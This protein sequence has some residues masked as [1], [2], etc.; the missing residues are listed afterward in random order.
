MSDISTPIA[1]SAPGQR[2]WIASSLQRRFILLISVILSILSFS[3][4]TYVI[5]QYREKILE[6]HSRASLQV[7]RLLEAS[8]QNAMLKRDL[9]GLRDIVKRLGEQ[10]DISA[11]LILNP[12]LKVTF[13]SLPGHVGATMDTPTVR[14]ALDTIQ[15]QTEYLA[16]DNGTDVLRS[17]NPVKNQ[18][19]CNQCHGASASHPVNGMLVVDYKAGAVHQEALRGSL[20]LAG[21]G[22]IVTLLT[23]LGLWAGLKRLVIDRIE[24]LKTA[25]EKI[26][27]SDFSVRV[28]PTGS[29]EIAKLGSSFNTMAGQISATH[30]RLNKAERFLQDIIDAVP[31]GIRVIADDFRIIKANRQYAL[32]TGSQSDAVLSLRCHESSHGRS[33]PCPH[34]MVTCPVH[35][36][37]HHS[38]SRIKT[39]Q[40]FVRSNG[41]EI[42]VEVTAERT[43]LTIDGMDCPVVIESIRDLDEQAR[44]SQEQRLSE[45]G[46][47]ATG[48]AHEIHNPLSSIALALVAIRLASS[49]PNGESNLAYME[50]ARAEIDKCLKVTDSLMRLSQP[51]AGEH[52]LLDL[53]TVLIS[54]FS[55][56]RFQAQSSGIDIELDL[57]DGLRVIADEGDLRM[58]AINLIQNSFHAMRQGGTLTV[59]ARREGDFITT[60]FMDTGTG[61]ARQNL[62]RIFL[63]FWTKRSDG[64]SGHGLGLTICRSAVER[65]G[66]TIQV[67]SEVG[68]GTVFTIRL[69]DADKEIQP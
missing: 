21:L 22:G 45:I 65:S 25:S 3:L 33:E 26:A 7:N 64:T 5:F 2:G 47:L 58:I 61:I 29:D 57:P 12:D 14:R 63:P 32:M 67:E 46:F 8:L 19:L 53:R 10:P 56:V 38:G 69:P 44:I 41:E 11:V 9:D 40:H 4:L 15:P 27:A 66:G 39:R 48:V 6:Q 13:S 16:Q 68:K 30:D 42:A 20:L 43:V 23:G 55:L 35:E 54:V 1:G 37:R 36:L 50:T 51:P 52:H 31:D 18:P 17:V 24:R 60:E 49:D 34:T 28:A 59:R 62:E